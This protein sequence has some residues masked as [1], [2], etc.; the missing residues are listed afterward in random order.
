MS[1]SRSAVALVAFASITPL[2]RADALVLKSSP[3]SP[4]VHL[5]ADI[6]VDPQADGSVIYALRSSGIIRQQ[7]NTATA[8]VNIDFVMPGQNVSR[9]PVHADRWSLVS[10]RL[11][12]PVFVDRTFEVADTH[13]FTVTDVSG[14]V[15]VIFDVSPELR[16]SVGAGNIEAIVTELAVVTTG[17]ETAQPNCNPSYNKAREDCQNQCVAPQR[18]KRFEY[19][20]TTAGVTISCECETPPANPNPGGNACP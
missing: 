17:S 19:S 6:K 13:R 5:Q 20:C 14:M 15:R 11:S 16:N 3:D 8:A 7:C 10:A 4:R 18:V 9:V 12:Q 2:V 1:L